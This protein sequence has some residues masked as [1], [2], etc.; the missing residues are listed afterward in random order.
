MSSVHIL[1]FVTH[2]EESKRISI[3]GQIMDIA[4]WVFD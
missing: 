2:L 1:S 3:D 4:G